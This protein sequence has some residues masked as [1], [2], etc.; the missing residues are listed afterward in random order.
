MNRRTVELKYI[1]SLEN[2]SYYIII[3]NGFACKCVY[4]S[5]NMSMSTVVNVNLELYV[6]GLR[7]DHDSL[8]KQ[9]NKPFPQQK[10][11]VNAVLISENVFWE[12]CMCEYQYDMLFRFDFNVVCHESKT[13]FSSRL[14]ILSYIKKT[15]KCLKSA[16]GW[17]SVKQIETNPLFA[18]Y[19]LRWNYKV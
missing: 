4:K 15:C 17:N 14:L 9:V 7:V 1:Y 16:T 8:F 5:S 10:V 19:C 18:I 11:I 12:M 13:Q 3:L 2:Y 6:Y